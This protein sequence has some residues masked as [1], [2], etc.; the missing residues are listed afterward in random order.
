MEILPKTWRGVEHNAAK[1]L[2]Q[3]PRQLAFVALVGP[4]ELV[5]NEMIACANA[6][7]YR[8]VCVAASGA[9]GGYLLPGVAGGREDRAYLVDRSWL[10]KISI[11]QNLHYTK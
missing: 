6:K 9:A 4:I 1:P 10:C 11:F 7:A 2:P 3:L 5:E 8:P